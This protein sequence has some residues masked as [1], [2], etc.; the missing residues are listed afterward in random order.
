[1]VFTELLEKVLCQGND[2]FLALSKGRYLE[3]YDFQSIIKIF[4][5]QM[6]FHVFF[7]VAIGRGNNPHVDFHGLV[8]ADSFDLSVLQETQELHLQRRRQ[9]ADFVEKQRAGVREL[10][11]TALLRVCAGEGAFFMAE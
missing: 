11:F 3:G 7:Q 2:I 6:V 8:S 1:M 4:A 5:E 10:E 9:F